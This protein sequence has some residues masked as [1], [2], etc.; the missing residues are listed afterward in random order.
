MIFVTPEILKECLE[1]SQESVLL[2]LVIGFGLWIMGGWGH[3]FCIVLLAT[4]LAGIFGLRNATVWGMQPL[5]AGLLLAVSAGALALSLARVGAFVAIG[6]ATVYLSRMVVPNWHEPVAIFVG[7]GLVGI[8]LFRFWIMT[9]ASLAGSLIMAYSILC[10]L[11]RHVRMDVL[12]WSEKNASLLSWSI[13]GLAI[14][15]ILI[16]LFAMRSGLRANRS[17][18]F[19]NYGDYDDEEGGSWYGGGNGRGKGSR[20][21]SYGNAFARNN[22]FRW[23]PLGNQKRR[24]AG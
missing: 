10:L 20:K 14:L 9:L 24:R 1:L 11:A 6:M 2:S 7:G 13:L 12:S 18:R 15:G 21:N 8:L 4:L 19:R 17:A 22:W 23:M 3:R 16:Q 5:V